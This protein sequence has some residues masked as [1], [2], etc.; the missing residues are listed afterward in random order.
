MTLRRTLGCLALILTL[1]G[2]VLTGGA[3]TASAERPQHRSASEAVRPKPRPTPSVPSSPAQPTPSVP[4]SPAPPTPSVS[5]SPAQPTA[6]ASVCSLGAVPVTRAGL[7]YCPGYVFGVRRTLYGQGTRLVL[8]RVV[9]TA[10]AGSQLQVSGGPACLPTEWCGQSIPNLTVR[11]AA[12]AATPTSGDVVDLFGSTTL[13][14][15]VPLDFDVIA[16]C[17]PAWGDC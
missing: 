3:T 16:H 12:G 2:A 1:T 11:F 14:G 10:V 9:V 7:D 8:K 5:N 13:G 15:L 17:D 4:S 6:S